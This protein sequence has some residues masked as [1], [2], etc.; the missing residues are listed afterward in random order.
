MSVLLSASC[1]REKKCRKDYDEIR[2]CVNLIIHLTTDT[3]MELFLRLF[4]MEMGPI[5]MTFISEII[6]DFNVLI[7]I[8]INAVS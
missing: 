8:V 4:I 7:L 3:I 6:I 1:F 2:I 5:E